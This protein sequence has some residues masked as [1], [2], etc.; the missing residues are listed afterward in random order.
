MDRVLLCT[1]ELMDTDKL[2]RWLTLGANIGVIA[3]LIFVALEVQTN[4]ESNLIAIHQNYTDNWLAINGTIAAS[5]ETAALLQRGL[6]GEELTDAEMRQLTHLV[7]MYL[8][9]S[10]HMLRLYDQGLISETAVRGAF[11][12][13]RKFAQFG[14]FREIIESDVVN[15]ERGRRIILEPDGLDRWLND[16]SATSGV[17]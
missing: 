2:N 4:T 12:M 11:R 7:H 6:D 13:V 5:P 14:R 9:Q 3:G 8:T 10:F 1:A 15:F 17:P 16:Q